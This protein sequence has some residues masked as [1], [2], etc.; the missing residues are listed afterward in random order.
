M[1]YA[2]QVARFEPS[3]DN[4]L[5]SHPDD[6]SAV[7]RI[8]SIYLRMFTEASISNLATGV[9]HQVVAT[10]DMNADVIQTIQVF[11]NG[12]FVDSGGP[13]DDGNDPD[14]DGSDDAG[15]GR[16]SGAVTAGS[17]TSFDGDIAIMRYYRDQ[18]FDA[19]DATQ[20]YD[21]LIP[22]PSSLALLGLGGLLIARRR[23]HA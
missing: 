8:D 20:N 22:E 10:I 19:T 13:A 2:G 1:G 21:A 5:S 15:L 9:F 23:R 7:E 3:R 12:S 11:H 14:W 18:V 4:A 6:V 17:Y 16:V